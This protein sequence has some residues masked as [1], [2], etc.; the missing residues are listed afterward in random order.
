MS[1]WS[2]SA[3]AVVGSQGSAA[4]AVPMAAEEPGS[5]LGRLLARAWSSAVASLVL[6]GLL[7]AA[8]WA[9]A[10]ALGGGG[11]IAPHWFY[12]PVI[13]AGLR[14]GRVG[15]GL[16]A[17]LAT[18]VA[19]PL[20]PADVSSHTPQDPSDWISRGIFFVLLGLFITEL[21]AQV[22]RSSLRAQRLLEEQRLR[23]VGEELV[24]QS[25]QRFRSLVQRATDMITVT[26]ASGRILHETPAVERILGWDPGARL[27]APITDFVEGGDRDL[28]EAILAE[29]VAHPERARIVE[30]RQLD[31]E[32]SLH[33]IE[34]TATNLLDEPTVHGLVLNHRVID[35]RKALE[36]ELT[37]RACHD[38]LTSLANRSL[39]QERVEAALR[40]RDLATHR[41]A[42]LFLDVD[43]F[44]TVN[45]G[46]G[47]DV[48]DRLLK[49]VASRLLR[50]V[51][52]EDV[53]ARLGGD[54][55]AVLVA[56]GDAPAVV[57][58]EVAERMLRA[59]RT[60]F[61]VAGHDM[62][63]GVS[64]GIACHDGAIV[65]ADHLLRQADIAMYRAKGEGKGQYAM[66]CEAMEAL[67]RSRIETERELRTAIDAGQLVVHYQPIVTLAT[68]EIVAVEALVRWDHPSRGMLPPSAFLPTAE[69]T[70]L[71]VPIG[72]L[73]LD[74][75]CCQ[76]RAWQRAGDVGAALQ[77]SV[78]LSSTQLRSDSVVEDVASAISR[79]GIAPEGLIIEVTETVLLEHTA[80]VGAVLDRLKALGV[81]IAIDD[82]G[83]G[84][85]SLSHLARFPV[86]LLKVDRSFISGISEGGS[87]S[88]L[89]TA[90]ARLAQ[91]LDLLTVAEGVEEAG[92]ARSLRELG[93]TYAQ[94]YY[95]SRPYDPSVVEGLLERSRAVVSLDRERRPA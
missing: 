52:S 76:L 32:G 73:V 86:D 61:T 5:P 16:A 82:F 50:C 49:E 20:L 89:I 27:G 71:I 83:T 85:S 19:G 74:A 10:W 31:A 11:H 4:P 75:A 51:R 8:S 58:A 13:L 3:E 70:G 34:A 30:V 7:L 63:V 53:V 68:G 62:L 66:F 93:Y 64:I 59:M 22:R 67:V 45:D 23:E 6:I 36:E 69:A 35:E 21:F 91:E 37:H 41:P 24:R 56:G 55:F 80:A 44:K 28:L 87:R 65:D 1:I 94:G 39:F 42:V 18:L 95:Y 14:F 57:A 54:E 77:V 72:R 2:A 25:E 38:V 43:D 60:P 79:S 9:L 47:H 78:N 84:Y 90:I 81:L 46:F 15:T 26:D 17:I 48:G 92:H 29:V 12:V 40:Q 88:R 33:W